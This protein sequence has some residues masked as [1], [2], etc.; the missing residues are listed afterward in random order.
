VVGGPVYAGSPALSI[1][2]KLNNLKPDQGA[3]VG[4]FGSDQGATTSSDVSMIR[5]SV[6]TLS[7]SGS[8]SNAIVVKIGQTEDLNT[9]ASD[10]VNQL[11]Q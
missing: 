9:R 7:P 8:L 11:V 1:K 5:S 4:L 6:S 3:K 10:F 2:D